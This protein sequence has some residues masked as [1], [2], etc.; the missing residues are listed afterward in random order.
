MFKIY[1]IRGTQY[2]YRKVHYHFYNWTSKIVK[3]T[4]NRP[5]LTSV[6]KRIDH[7]RVMKDGVRVN[8]FLSVRAA[9]KWAK[10]Q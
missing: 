6:V 9:R 3:G 8:S 4:R 5:Q 2:S 7:I 10:R 1:N